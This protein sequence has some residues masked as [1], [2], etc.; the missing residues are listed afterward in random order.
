VEDS[1]DGGHVEPVGCLLQEYGQP[2][3][4]RASNYG[5]VYMHSQ[6]K[7]VPDCLSASGL[8]STML[9]LHVWGIL[10]SSA[11]TRFMLKVWRALVMQ[12]VLI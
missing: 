3:I 1:G 10:G 7:S 12:D 8:V 9:S 4:H 2:S 5:H 6:L 11:G